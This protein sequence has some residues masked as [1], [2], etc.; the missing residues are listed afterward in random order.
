MIAIASYYW[1]LVGGED[2][3]GHLT[4]AI[5]QLDSFCVDIMGDN[6]FSIDCIT[7]SEGGAVVV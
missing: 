3:C 1:L 2:W 6:V 4:T 5:M 7:N